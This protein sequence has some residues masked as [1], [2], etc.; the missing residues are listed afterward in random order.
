M[1]LSAGAFGCYNCSKKKGKKIELGF[2][3]YKYSEKKK[4]KKEELLK[5]CT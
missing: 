5:S 4:K 1:M 3:N 2:Y